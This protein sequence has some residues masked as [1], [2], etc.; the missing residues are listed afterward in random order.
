MIDV[1]AGLASTH[2]SM[3]SDEAKIDIGTSQIKQQSSRSKNGLFGYE[4]VK[5][6]GGRQKEVLFGCEAVY[7]TELIARKEM[8]S[9]INACRAFAKEKLDGDM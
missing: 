4:I 5:M 7:K 8:K 9:I 1:N 3:F 6:D 2:L